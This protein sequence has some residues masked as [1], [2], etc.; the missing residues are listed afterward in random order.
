MAIV[1]LGLVIVGSITIMTRGLAA[2][3]LALEHSQVRQSINSQLEMLQ[4][5]R[6]QYA[7]SASSANGV[8]WASIVAAANE[9]VVD[10]N[11]CTVTS[12][13]TGSAFYLQNNGTQIVSQAFSAAVQPTTV[14]LPGQGMWIES[15][16]S[17]EDTTVP[18]NS[19]RPA[20]V[21]FVVRACWQG[22]GSAGQQQTVTGIRLYDP[23][24]P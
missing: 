22:S 20:F 16:R 15:V 13:K 11:G 3:Q 5:L 1:V 4:L 19:I 21:D 7:Q 24:R 12:T 6:D 14:A 8:Q 9:S 18:A 23:T 17:H 2:A 10:Y